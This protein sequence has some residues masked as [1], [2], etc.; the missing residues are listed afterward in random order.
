MVCTSQPISRLEL[1]L[2]F[3]SEVELSDSPL[4]ITPYLQIATICER[5]ILEQDGALTLF[6]VIDRFMISGQTDEMPP[7]VLQ[8]TVVVSF[9]SGNFRGRLELTL[10]TLDPDMIQLT[11]ANFPLM[12]EG[13]AERGC[14]TIAQVQMQVKDEG[15]YWITVSLRGQECTR[16]PLR[17]IYQKQ[18]TV[19]TGG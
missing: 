6:R 8:F 12:F 4:L 13:D 14:I 18:P 3:S 11:Q 15:L 10:T 5:Y 16:I 19:L 17:V 2:Q 7:T 1:V 9:R